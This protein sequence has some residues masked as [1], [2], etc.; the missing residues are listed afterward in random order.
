MWTQTAQKKIHYN[1]HTVFNSYSCP[2]NWQ[3]Y[4][5]NDTTALQ[6]SAKSMTG[7]W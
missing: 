7:N 5:A 1:Y 2:T 6:F 3:E 4:G